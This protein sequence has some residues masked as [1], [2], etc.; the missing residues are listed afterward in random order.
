MRLAFA[1]RGIRVFA[2]SLRMALRLRRFFTRLGV[3]ALT[4]MFGGCPMALRRGFVM[5]RCL[6]MGF[7]RH[8]IFPWLVSMPNELAK[9]RHR[10]RENAGSL[11]QINLLESRLLGAR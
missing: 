4:V 10:S 6:R 11:R 9:R 3:I 1:V 2:R 7:P 8:S 5:F